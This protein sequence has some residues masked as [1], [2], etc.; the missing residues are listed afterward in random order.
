M[1]LHS[2]NSAC[3]AAAATAHRVNGRQLAS[4]G[5][6]GK[7]LLCLCISY[8]VHTHTL[9]MLCTHILYATTR[10]QLPKPLSLVCV[11]EP[12]RSCTFPALASAASAA[13]FCSLHTH[14]HTTTTYVCAGFCASLT[15]VTKCVKRDKPDRSK[16]ISRS[17][18]TDHNKI[19]HRAVELQHVFGFP[20][21]YC[22]YEIVNNMTD[23]H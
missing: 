21:T 14:I 18:M 2:H 3:A 10:S 22:N 1:P 4:G 16:K 17:D 15:C 13:I 23:E 11:D 7:S 8:T 12:C 20:Q 5:T 19:I 6:G 9:C